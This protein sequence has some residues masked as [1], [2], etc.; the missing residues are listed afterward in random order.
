[1]QPRW[2]GTLAVL[3]SLSPALLPATPLAAQDDDDDRRPRVYSFS[4][5]RPRI[6][7]MVDSRP[8]KDRDLIGARLAGITE[9]GPA[10]KAG[11]KEG[12]IITRFN[13][14][15]LGGSTSDD[16][17]QS[18]PA[19]RLVEL[20]R[21]LEPGDTV[22]VEY[23]RGS[24]SRKATLVAENLRGFAGG[25]SFSFQMPEMDHFRVRP[26]GLPRMLMP[27]G[28]SGPVRLLMEERDGMQLTALSPELGEYFGTREGILVLKAPK[29]S[30]ELRAGDVILSIGGRTPTSVAHAR[31]ILG[32]Y[33]AGETAKLEIMRKQKKQSITWKAPERE[34]ELRWRTPAPRERVKIE[35]S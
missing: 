12:D 22:Q 8:D 10:D 20:A 35:R 21:K 29:E 23:R 32:S 27:D 3:L 9:G 2:S 25:R 19:A 7:V 34:D 15:A 30:S 6:G 24:E 28:E 31:R 18:G 14:I 5:S 26:D 13:G 1:M 16:D 17:D 11:L 33:D 4:T